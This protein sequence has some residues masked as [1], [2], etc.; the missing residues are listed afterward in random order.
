VAA[1]G[2]FPPGS[3]G[4]TLSP[5]GGLRIRSMR[6]AKLIERRALLAQVIVTIIGAFD[7]LDD[8]GETACRDIATDTRA[9]HQGTMMAIIGIPVLRLLL[10]R[11]QGVWCGWPEGGLLAVTSQTDSWDDLSNAAV[12]AAGFAAMGLFDEINFTARGAVTVFQGRLWD[13]GRQTETRPG[14]HPAYDP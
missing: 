2:E 13:R 10:R 5:A 1:T 6:A 7:A 9:P 4:T 3:S 11:H 14:G 12:V 8:V